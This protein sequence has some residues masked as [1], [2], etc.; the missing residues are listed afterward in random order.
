MTENGFTEADDDDEPRKNNP[1]LLWVDKYSPQSYSDL[2]SEEVVMI[3]II[4]VVIIIIIMTQM[5]KAVATM[6]FFVNTCLG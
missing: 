2:I 4:I 1:K 3:I 5:A 6:N